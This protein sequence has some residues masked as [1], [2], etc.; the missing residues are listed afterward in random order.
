M[1]EE[2]ITEY[3]LNERHPRGGVKAAAFHSL[4]F[5]INRPEE[6]R[7]ALQELAITT[8]MTKIATGSGP[9]YVGVGA[10]HTEWQGS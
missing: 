10:V 9:K 6:F 4:G 5:S 3:L 1:A 8:D 2:K 7:S